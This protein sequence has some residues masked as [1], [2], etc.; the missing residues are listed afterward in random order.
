VAT[1]NQNQ[2]QSSTGIGGNVQPESVATFNQN[3]HMT[4]LTVQNV[5]MTH[6]AGFADTNQ[7][8]RARSGNGTSNGIRV[9]GCIGEAII[10]TGNA[11]LGFG[12]GTVNQVH[13]SNC[14]FLA[15]WIDGTSTQKTVVNLATSNRWTFYNNHFEVIDVDSVL[16]GSDVFV[17]ALPTVTTQSYWKNNTLHPGGSSIFR[18][19]GFWESQTVLHHAY[20]DGT[21]P[22]LLDERNSMTG[23][24]KVMQGT[25]APTAGAWLR[26]DFVRNVA[27]AT[28]NQTIGATNVQYVIFGWVCTSAG[29]P[30]TWKECRVLTGV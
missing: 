2:W 20:V 1:F 14:R 21:I 12:N 26:G 18:A 4:N 19:T 3:T 17:V 8:M 30:G 22:A 23:G 10:G 9:D 15:S 27:P 28:A 6:S 7:F 25:A 24:L 5:R 16:T 11:M 29:S 13:V